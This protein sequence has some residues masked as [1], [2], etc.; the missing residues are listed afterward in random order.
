M[1]VAEAT[2][3]PLSARPHRETVGLTQARAQ[4]LLDL[5]GP[6]TLDSGKKRSAAALFA[7]QFRDIM[8]MILLIAAGVS[9]LIGE[10]AD[11]VPIAVI[12]VVNAVLGFIQEYRAER[13]LEKLAELT[14]PTAKVWRDGKLVTLPAEQ[15][16]IGDVIELEAGDRVPADCFVISCAALSCDEALL[17]GESVTCAK[18]P[19]D[20]EP[21]IS[22][23]DLEYLVY[24]GTVVMTGRCRAEVTAVGK[25]TLMG[26]VS[27]LLAESE[28]EQTPLQKRLG[29]LGRT[30]A[31]ICIGV[32]FVVFAAGMIRGEDVMEMLMTSVSIAV[33]AIPEGLPAAVTIALALAVRRMLARNALIT[34]LHSVETLGCASVICTDKTGTLTMGRMTVSKITV[35]SEQD[36]ELTVSAGE[37][38]T[39]SSG[40]RAFPWDDTGLR[41]LLCC[42]AVC[43]NARLSETD[44]SDKRD[45]GGMISGLRAHGDPTEAAI[46][47]AAAAGGI[48]AE[49]FRRLRVDEQ[50][51]DSAKKY[52]TV[53]VREEGVEKIYKKGAPDVLL[54]GCGYLIT[55]SG[56]TVL[57]GEARKNA[58]SK[59]CDRYASE[60]M[61]VLAF[62]MISQGREILLGF[63]A[64]TDPPRPEAAGAVKECARA[65]IRTVMITGDH[66]LTACAVAKETG[67]L[68]SGMRAVTGQ[69]LDAMSDDELDEALDGIAVFARVSPEHK[70]RIVRAFRR[71]GKICAMTG[72]GV[73]DAP[74]VSEAYIGVSMGISGTDVTRQAADCIL[75]DDN[76]ATLAAAVRE[77][78]TIYGNIRKFVRYLISCN[79]GEVLTM[80]GGIIMGLPLVLVPAQLLLVNLVTDG[81]PAIALGSE[82]SED[83]VMEQP[84]RRS[85]ESFFSGGLLYRMIIR[86][87]LIGIVTLASFTVLLKLGSG[88]EAARTG[89]LV[90]LIL[91]QLIHS[92][93]CKSETKPLFRVKFR[94][95]PFLIIS[96]LISLACMLACM[97][98]SPLAGVFSLVQ[99]GFTGWLVSVLSAAVLPFAAALF[100]KIR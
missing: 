58:I 94:N 3:K 91:S 62:S 18:R 2:R 99:L 63:M 26:S 77:G 85:N 16:V 19:Y 79:I 7:G 34:R 22:G 47:T 100:L 32:C 45:R 27:G 71:R 6:N 96:V 61:R 41:E 43:N 15:L 74:A 52:M 12:V 14:A 80:L 5:N 97:Y 29:E 88:L 65:G 50:P 53:T 89:A 1:T 10:Y 68:R 30:L 35:C 92:F 82:P 13:T 21:E 59:L 38:L 48:D 57:L 37:G 60:G 36:R 67:I 9:V 44:I 64:L 51:F 75:L 39:D 54:A 86:G 46:L 40:A 70:L 55:K 4:R 42:A 31:M 76:F 95:N 25:S 23:P 66:K 8:V 17:T 69:E 81:L 33:A 98:V 72:D 24:M 20:G 49:S 87:A 56:N 11:A 28:H 73:N 93:E 83:G 78:R 84:P 90:T